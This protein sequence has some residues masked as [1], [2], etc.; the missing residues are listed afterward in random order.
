MQ[1]AEWLKTAPPKN[2]T[3]ASVEAI[4]SRARQMQGALKDGAFPT[5]SVFERL[6]D[7]A[8]DEII[9]CLRNLN[10]VM[11]TTA[12]YATHT[13]ANRADEKETIE[14]TLDEIQKGVSN[15]CTAV[16]TPFLFNVS[17]GS[18]PLPAGDAQGDRDFHRLMAAADLDAALLLKEAIMRE[19]PC[20]YSF[21]VSYEKL[22]FTSPTQRENSGSSPRQRRFKLG[23]LDGHAV[24]METYKYKEAPDHSG[25]PPPQ[26]LQQLRKITGLLCHPK[27]KDF[28]IL[29]CV[30]FFRDRLRRDLG[31]VFRP[32]PAFDSRY[33]GGLVTL[34]QLYKMHRLVPLGQR[35]HLAWALATATE[36]FHRVG[37]VHQSIRSGNIAFTAELSSSSSSPA[38]ESEA[39]G[40]QALDEGINNQA[41][42]TSLLDRFDL[43]NPL[44]FG[45]EYS[46]ADDT[47]T[48]L[49]EDH[50]LANNLYRIP[51][52]WGRP[53]A[54]FEKSHDVYSL[55]VVLLE[56]ALWKDVCSVV[57][58]SLFGRRVVADEVAK[59]LASKCSKALSHQV[60]DIFV[61]CILTCL[62]FSKQT[63]GMDEY[64]TQLY[65]QQSVITPI[66]RALYKV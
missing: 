2:V 28:H 48:Y 9:R 23:V 11:T 62:E 35:I 15:V 42:A 14:T 40:F 24:I 16:E 56:I 57:K 8:K 65:F 17:K 39:A 33:R 47:A 13:K 6:S 37:W 59:T 20:R 21:E 64:E 1:I 44:L 41:T 53:A 31:L 50:S 63:K 3:T 43:G 25:E 58:H 52:R 36:H 10:T 22:D 12:G 38:P 49:E 4:V 60:G 5:G 32:P 45:F 54:R 46:R 26:T 34:S 18:G 30:G 27:R 19:D 29:P 61:R 51:D 55:G 7:R 66:G